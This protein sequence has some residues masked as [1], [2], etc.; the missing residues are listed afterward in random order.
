[1]RGES[2]GEKR[3]SYSI[4]SWLDLVLTN[5]DIRQLA[6]FFCSPPLRVYSPPVKSLGTRLLSAVHLLSSLVVPKW[7]SSTTS[8]FLIGLVSFSRVM[9]L[10]LGGVS[11]TG[12]GEGRAGRGE[13]RVERRRTGDGEGRAGRGEGRV[14]RRRTGDGEGEQDSGRGEEDGGRGEEGGME[15]RLGERKTVARNPNND[16]R[17]TNS[18]SW[19]PDVPEV[20]VVLEVVAGDLGGQKG[21]L[22]NSA[23]HVVS[24]I[25]TGVW[26]QA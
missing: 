7:M 15:G 23:S 22:L 6:R 1:M 19:L 11:R 26:I 25:S 16:S 10:G 3:S 13:G 24:S 12:D 17:N 20:V 8:L 18:L 2:D 14:E 9:L 4:L 5:R 21:T